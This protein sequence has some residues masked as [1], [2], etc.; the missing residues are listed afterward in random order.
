MALNVSVRPAGI[1]DI[2]LIQQMADVVFRK[3]Y[4]SI[5]SPSQME[6]M[7]NWMY[8]TESLYGQIAGKD[9]YFRIAMA[10]GQPA[11]YVS[12]EFERRLDDGR[13]LYHLQKLYAMPQY[14]HSGVGRDMIEHV[15]SFL[16]SMNP[17]GCRI[18]LN[19]NR[20]NAAV[21]FYRHMGLYCDRQGDF[22]IGN[23]FYMNDYIFAID[24]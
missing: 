15:E 23:G 1:E 4:A 13:N 16:R 6:Y 21:G 11:G 12:F 20:N 19:V 7:M 5:L 9:K 14:Q 3:T 8:S 22:P 2:G 18:E 17:D 10:D 24:L